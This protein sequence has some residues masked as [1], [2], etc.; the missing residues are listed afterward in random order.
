MKKIF[1]HPLFVMG[2]L[3]R[4]ILTTLVA[5]SPV[6]NWYVPFLD[7]TTFSPNPWATWTDMDGDPLAFPYGY[8]M[9]FTFWPLI[10]LFKLSGL[11]LTWAYPL[12]LLAV[13]VA[14]LFL[15]QRMF[16]KR[17]RLLLVTYWFSPIIIMASYA[18]GLNDLV[19]VFFLVFSLYLVKQL[20]FSLAGFF[21][22]ASISAK[23]SMVLSFPF[24]LIYF[25]RNKSRR[26]CFLP[27]CKGAAIGGAILLVPFGFSPSA[28][29]MLFHNPEMEKIYHFGLSLG[30]H[31]TIYLVPLAYSFLL[32]ATWRTKRLN[33]DLVY[34]ILGITFLMI[35]LMTPTSPGWF[36]WAIPFLVMHQTS[37]DNRVSIILLGIFSTLYILNSFILMDVIPSYEFDTKIISLSHTA[38]VALGT[39]IAVRIGRESVRKSDYFRW[40]RRPLMIGIA[41]DSG[42]GKDTLA[43]GLMG[44]FG[45]HSVANISGD[46][47]HLWD[48]KK[49]MWQVMTHLNPMANDLERFARD[50]ISLADGKSICSR[51]YDHEQ[52]RMGRPLK[53]RSNDVIIATGLHAFYIPLLRDIFNLKIYLDMDEDLRRYFKIGRDTLQRGHTR[54]KV[55]LS[56][57]SRKKDSQQF[58]GPQKRYADL[59]LSLRPLKVPLKEGLDE[60]TPDL[61]L[62]ALSRHGFNELALRRALV[63][64]C[65]LRVDVTSDHQASEV[66]LAIEGDCR[67]SDMALVARN[68]CPKMMDF[69]DINPIW[70]DGVTGLMQLLTLSHINQILTK[71]VV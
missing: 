27:F 71:R 60:K 10:T 30:P 6:V 35:V 39:I 70:E 47:Y 9:W 69:L 63:G 62:L 4:L 61:G 37:A 52:G 67:A 49:P 18:L 19:P 11:P 29:N 34:T 17:D 25:I 38:M 1:T 68:V 57:E 50:V 13:D 45:H 43:K 55:L 56:L 58:V 51:H 15:L 21:A 14:L 40:G 54:E 2:L 42:S 32:Y 46:N 20:Q 33:F 12:T 3:V 44:L 28:M 64:I 41:G 8:V 16:P 36:I 48:R 23:L 59:I 65:G 24:F 26:K 53:I 66:T 5:P 31:V 22:V 7:I